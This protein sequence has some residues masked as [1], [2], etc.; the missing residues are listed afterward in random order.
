LCLDLVTEK[1]ADGVADSGRPIYRRSVSGFA[2]REIFH[3]F[4]NWAYTASKRSNA[5]ARFLITQV[6]IGPTF[7]DLINP[8][9]F[10]STEFSSREFAS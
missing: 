9:A 4:L 5:L 3:D 7:E 10:D 8:E 2:Y 1:I 6:L